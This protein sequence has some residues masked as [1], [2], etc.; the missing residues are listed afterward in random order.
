MKPL[1]CVHGFLG[2]RIDFESFHH[3]HST[4][5]FDG[6]V[7]HTYE[8][9]GHGN[10]KS[11]LKTYDLDSLAE[12]FEI[13]LASHQN[14]VVWGYSLGGRILQKV[15]ERKKVRLSGVILESTGFVQDPAERI[16]QDRHWAQKIVS[17]EVKVFLEE[18]YSQD[19]F[20]SLRSHPN[21]LKILE[22]RGSYQSQT[23][24][25]IL[26]EASPALNSLQPPLE[27][28]LPSLILVGQLDLKYSKMWAPLIDKSPNLDIRILENVGHALHIESPAETH[29]QIQAWLKKL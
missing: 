17:L 11:T 18:W 22:L 23:L 15:I 28:P 21:Y 24:A 13:Y 19:L 16:H 12:D 27:I 9:P 1:V 14:P 8:L 3:N 20:K 7:T 6:Y 29:R 25:Q 5:N 10:N 2:S 4:P 26:L